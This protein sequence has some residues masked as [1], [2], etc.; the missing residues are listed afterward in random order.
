MTDTFRSLPLGDLRIT[1]VSDGTAVRDVS[2]LLTRAQPEALAALLARQD[3]QPGVALPIN[4]FVVDD[5]ARVVLIDAGAGDLFKPEG[6]LLPE[7]LRRAGYPPDAIDAVLLTHIHADH[8]GGLMQAG[9]Q[10]F[11]RATVHVPRRDL[12]LFLDPVAEQASPER[13]RHIYREARACLGPYLAQGRVV[14]FDGDEQL[15]PGITSREASG[16]TPGHSHFRLESGGQRLDVL[17]DTIHVADFQ[18][19]NPEAAV[20]LDIDEEP[21]IARRRDAL[22]AAVAGGYLVAFDHVPF[23]GIGHI[24]RSGQGYRWDPIATR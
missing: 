21:A 2:R 19:A 20:I 6:G 7:N 3:H 15:S 18:F 23:P 8:S 9:A 17:G 10:V 11:P 22:D 5:G 13:F 16:H 1:V 24:H 12:E 4:A 14:P